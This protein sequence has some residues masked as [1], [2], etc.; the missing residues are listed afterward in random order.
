MSLHFCSRPWEVTDRLDGIEVA[1]DPMHLEPVTLSTFVDDLFDLACES[2]GPN[3]YLDLQ[4]VHA[5]PSLFLGK[6]LSLNR[7][8][9][10]VG[11]Q[12]ILSN[13]TDEL[14]T[15]LDATRLTTQLHVAGRRAETSC[16]A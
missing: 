9:R 16:S 6:L 10:E 3:L 4:Q 7:K 8:Q 13:V 12:L 2:H 14:Y 15:C 5:V 11:G 1:L